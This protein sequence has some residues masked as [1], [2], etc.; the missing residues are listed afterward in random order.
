VLVLWGGTDWEFPEEM[1][2]EWWK[3]AYRLFV[4]QSQPAEK[5]KPAGYIKEVRGSRTERG[6]CVCVW[7]AVKGD[8]GWC[9]RLWNRD[10]IWIYFHRRHK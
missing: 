10:N 9:A 6:R 1:G 3:V 2:L 7:A 8:L 5:Y 4:R